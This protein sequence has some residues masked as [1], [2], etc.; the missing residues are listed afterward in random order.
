[1]DFTSTLGLSKGDDLRYV[2]DVLLNLTGSLVS[3][4]LPR[5][6]VSLGWKTKATRIPVLRSGTQFE[7]K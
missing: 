3:Y 5:R 2:G 1:M 6:K 4:K 7:Q